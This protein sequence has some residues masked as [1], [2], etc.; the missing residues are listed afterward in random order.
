VIKGTQINLNIPR[1]APRKSQVVFLL[2][3]YL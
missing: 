2:L 1:S 3:Y